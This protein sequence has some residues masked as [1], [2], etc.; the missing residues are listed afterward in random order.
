MNVNLNCKEVLSA[1]KTLK[2][3]TKGRTN[4]PILEYAYI[5]VEN[6][7]TVL[8]V[9][10]L[11]SWASVNLNGEYNEPGEVLVEYKKLEKLLTGKTGSFALVGKDSQISMSFDNGLVVNRLQDDP[12]MT[13]ADY[14]SFPVIEN[15]HTDIINSN[16]FLT[17][18]SRC[19]YAMNLYD[20]RFNLNAVCIKDNDCVATDGHRLE[21]TDLML[22]EGKSILLPI[23]SVMLL[24]KKGLFEKSCNLSIVNDDKYIS[25]SDSETCVVIRK[26]EGDY[27]DYTRVIPEY[28]PAIVIKVDRKS[29]LSTVKEF[30][31]LVNDRDPSIIVAINETVDISRGDS[32]L[33]TVFYQIVRLNET[34][35]FKINRQYFEDALTASK[36]GIVQISYFKEGAPIVFECE[37]QF[38]LVMPMRD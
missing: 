16:E 23:E 7:S 9:T 18:I 2:P 38:S 37:D 8:Q 17:A 12:L 31:S 13:V 14:P 34:V 35:T 22:N 3:I 33:S 20:S 6:G 4:L 29:L 21:K 19:K 1:L 5:R 15:G 32:K 25:I 10:D 36:S 30:T 24:C 28:S 11:T 27:P 26:I